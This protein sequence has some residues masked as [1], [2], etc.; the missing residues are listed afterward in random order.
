M[1]VS[2]LLTCWRFDG[3][4][5]RVLIELAFLEW[6]RHRVLRDA[7]FLG[8]REDKEPH[9][10]RRVADAGP[11]EPRGPCRPALAGRVAARHPRQSGQRPI[12]APVNHDRDFEYFHPF[13]AMLRARES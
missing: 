4:R 10:P 9:A 2:H 5:L 8:L 7:R 1:L 11:T 12:G 6:D 13:C 3:C